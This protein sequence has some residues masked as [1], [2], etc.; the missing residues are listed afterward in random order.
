MQNL[1]VKNTLSG[2]V[3]EFVP[4]KQGA[5]GLYACGITV[6]DRCHIGH[7]R[8]FVAIDNIIRYLRF[9]GY[10][11]TFVRNI[12]DIDDKIIQKC[13]A[14]KQTLKQLT[15][16]YIDLMHQDFDKLNLL[17]PDAEPK[18][19][20]HIPQIIAMIASLKTKG[21]AYQ[22]NN[23]D[24]YFAINQF[25][26]YGQLSG[27][28]L[29]EMIE[30]FRVAVDTDKNDAKDFVL[31]KRDDDQQFTWDSPFGRGRPGWHIECSAM[32]CHYLG[33]DFDFH[34]GGGDL[35]FPHHENEIAQSCCANQGSHFAKYWLHTGAV[36]M[37]DAKMSKSL[38]NVKRVD[39][40][41]QSYHPE[42]L[43]YY[44]A[45]SHYRSA[46]TYQADSLSA[47]KRSLDKLYHCLKNFDDNAQ[48]M[49]YDPKVRAQN[50]WYQLFCKAMSDDFNTSNALAVLH[51]LAQWINRNPNSSDQL[52]NVHLLVAL[53]QQLGLLQAEPSQYFSYGSA[54]TTANIESLIEQRQLAR[55]A[56]DFQLA[57]DIRSQLLE[58][59]IQIEDTREGVHWRRISK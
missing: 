18:A 1:K 41:L 3:E 33:V 2:T 13:Q 50:R 5:I 17:P 29:N 49:F 35:I 47:A 38:G 59:G 14:T 45:S 16:Y 11:V 53:G 56:K 25:K 44:F 55:K 37:G 36:R 58:L 54:D 8:T 12:T 24:V 27:K 32:A 30:G 51:Q 19:S 43:R 48:Y 40:L 10:R 52:E 57:D 7:M 9:I 34:C 6:Y 21:F 31:W 42:V 28:N 15:E 4:I 26:D 39:E 46:M 22:K 23:G 20:Q